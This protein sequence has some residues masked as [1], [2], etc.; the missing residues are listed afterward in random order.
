V[1]RAAASAALALA[2]LVAPA[3]SAATPRTNA[4]AAESQFMCVTCNIPLLEAQSAQADD[5]KAYVQTLVDQGDT[6][7]QIKQAMVAVYGT[8]VLALPPASGFDA[9]VYVVPIVAVA[10]LVALVVIL[11]PR[12]RRRRPQTAE[13]AVGAP[14]LSPS[15]AAR[16]DADLARFD[17]RR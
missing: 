15:D 6:M 9:T 13:A 16:L 11:L 4:Y 14:A 12:W 8:A 3:A 10:A 1:R 7:A 2:L 17:G 5:E